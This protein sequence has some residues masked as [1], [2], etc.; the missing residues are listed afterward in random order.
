MVEDLL[1]KEIIIDAISSKNY[2]VVMLY[3][4]FV[5]LSLGMIFVAVSTL[6][7]GVESELLLL[8]SV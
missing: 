6:V 3:T 4:M 5:V 8:R 7:W 2:D 1:V